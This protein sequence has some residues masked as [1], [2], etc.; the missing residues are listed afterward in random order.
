MPKAQVKLFQHKH[1]QSA[2]S[3]N[4]DWTVKICLGRLRVSAVKYFN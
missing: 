4:S 3:A 1:F 2:Y